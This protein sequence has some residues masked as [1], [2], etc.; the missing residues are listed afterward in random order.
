MSHPT[1]NH[2]AHAKRVLRYLNGTMSFFSVYHV[3]FLYVTIALFSVE[4]EY[5]AISVASLEVLFLRQ[6]ITNLD[7]TPARSTRMLEDYIGCMALA[8]NPMTTGKTKH[9]DVRCHFIREVVKSKAAF[10]EYCP[11]TDMLPD[12]LTKFSLPTTL[13]LQHVSRMLSGTYSGPSPV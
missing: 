4:T 13:H 9:I 7:H 1:V 5:M 3:I 8:T 6:P 12:V 11:T 10:L 2:W